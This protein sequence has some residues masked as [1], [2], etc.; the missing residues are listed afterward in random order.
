MSAVVVD[1]DVFSYLYKGD[2]R[3]AAYEKHLLGTQPHLAFAT[4]AELYRWAV[5]R[6][7]A[8]PRMSTLNASIAKYTVLHTDDA[9]VLA[10]A[11]VMSIKGR[12]VAHGDA[13]VA[14]VALRHG[15]PLLTHNRKHFEGIHDL[16]V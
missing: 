12:P 13:W 14:A 6:G 7:W 16:V 10:W 9:I 8:T 15:M 1:T 2:S 11:R 3:A 5:Q 4:V